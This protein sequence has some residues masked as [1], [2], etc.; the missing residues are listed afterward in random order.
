MLTA[1]GGSPGQCGWL[2]DRFGM[3]WQIIPREMG[4]MMGDP[5]PERSKRAME[6]MLRMTKIDLDEMR[7]AIAGEPVG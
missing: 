7:R 4:E 6:A 1:D 3:S 5:N 2:K